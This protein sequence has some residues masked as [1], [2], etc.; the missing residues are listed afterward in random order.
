MASSPTAVEEGWH[1]EVL[2]Y[3]WVSDPRHRDQLVSCKNEMVK[4]CFTHCP[5]AFGIDWSWEHALW[6]LDDLSASFVARNP[7]SGLPDVFPPQTLKFFPQ[8]WATFFG[9]VGMVSRL[10]RR[11]KIFSFSLDSDPRH[12]DQ[13]VSCKNEMVKICFTHCPVAFGIDWSWEHALWA[14]DDLSASFVARFTRRF[15]LTYE[16]MTKPHEVLGL[17]FATRV[18]GFIDQMLMDWAIVELPVTVTSS[19]WSPDVKS[20]D[21][22]LIDR[23]VTYVQRSRLFHNLIR[24]TQRP[25][26][27]V[28]HNISRDPGLVDCTVDL[29]E[30]ILELT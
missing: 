19:G 9:G 15:H 8:V 12:R 17:R 23:L 21:S 20:D 13:L 2:L 22:L 26:G 1:G 30:S 11:K 29:C 14:L 25:P 3:S 28:A 4:I 6:A 27:Y 24:T 7:R 18:S 10:E 5:V 16:E